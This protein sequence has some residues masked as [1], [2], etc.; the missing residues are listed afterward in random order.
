MKS[1]NKKI[2]R[3]TSSGKINTKDRMKKD[4][5]YTNREIKKLIEKGYRYSEM[6]E[7]DVSGK[8]F[9]VILLLISLALIVSGGIDK[10]LYSIVSG[11][12]LLI[13]LSYALK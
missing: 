10:N 4:M 1:K 3:A 6:N 9:I 5:D 13:W 8:V 11:S 7:I 12:I 2:P